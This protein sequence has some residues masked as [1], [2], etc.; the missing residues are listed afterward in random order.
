MFPSSF[1]VPFHKRTDTVGEFAWGVWNCR[2]AFPA[3]SILP[4]FLANGPR[5]EFANSI[6]TY[7]SNGLDPSHE[8]VCRWTTTRIGMAF[9]AWRT[10]EGLALFRLVRWRRRDP[11]A[12]G[13]PGA[14]VGAGREVGGAGVDRD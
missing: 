8:V 11:R 13:V 2:F 3:V 1:E 14:S 5:R 9:R 12:V 6:R 10:A 4:K 7:S